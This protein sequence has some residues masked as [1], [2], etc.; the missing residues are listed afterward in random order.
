MTVLRE[1]FA[2]VFFLLAASI[3][4]HA[5]DGALDAS[6]I[7]HG[8]QQR[9]VPGLIQDDYALG[10][11]GT[12]QG[13]MTATSLVVQPDGNILVAG[14]GW[15]TYNAA[16]QNACVLRRYYPNGSADTTFGTNGVVV[17][18]RQNV[19][20]ATSRMD[21]YWSSIALQADGKILLAGELVPDAPYAS[22]AWIDRYN[23]DGSQDGSFHNGLGNGDFP[24][25]YAKVIVAG[26]G[27]I[28]LAGNYVRNGFSDTDFYVAVLDSGG[29]Y[30]YALNAHFDLG[31]SHNDTVSSAVLDTIHSSDFGDIDTLYL[32]GVAD[33]G[34]YGDGFPHHSCAVAA[35]TRYA[36]AAF[37]A[38]TAFGSGGK[39]SYD[40]AVGGSET[41]TICR[42]ATYG[43][44]ISNSLAPGVTDLI[45][46][47]ERYF[48][49]SA[50]NL[51][52][53]YALDKIDVNGSVV[54]ADGSFQFF[55]DAQEPGAFNSINAMYWD[56]IG[57]LVVAGYAGIGA[58][59]NASHAPSDA[60]IQRFNSDLSLDTS[61]GISTPG[62]TNLTLDEVN[63]QGLLASQREWANGIA[64]DPLHAR[65]IVIGER[66]PA[67][68]IDQN[69]YAWLLGAVHDGN[70]VVADRIF[71]N[72]FE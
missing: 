1:R 3:P 17:S 38:S 29:V 8:A 14:F 18:N 44:V 2:L 15:N 11:T 9:G 32:V 26:S 31:G 63:A 68:G 33:A 25:S 6:W 28:L 34:N 16:D 71:A 52:S 48:A 61:F 23:A 45:V 67:Y 24:R 66:S 65:A 30:K 53:Y 21:C 40:F 37:A 13:D 22:A 57:K 35:F 41:D 59:G 47:G 70:V 51:A 60:G 12:Y 7:P 64:A 72:G 50:G 43:T 58:N 69:L 20:G 5:N 55:E 36:G 46:G 10:G 49:P 42:T 19:G 62:T 39:R 54:H 56:D 27:E 4:S